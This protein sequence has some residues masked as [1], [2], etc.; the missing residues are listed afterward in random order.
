MRAVSVLFVGS[1]RSP[2]LAL[3]GQA[4]APTRRG[5]RLTDRAINLGRCLRRRPTEGTGSRSLERR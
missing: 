5:A 3:A 1:L 2:A 4:G